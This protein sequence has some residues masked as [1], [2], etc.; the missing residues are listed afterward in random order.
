MAPSS[1]RKLSNKQRQALRAMQER[2]WGANVK[3]GMARAGKHSRE[4]RAWANAKTRCYNT[5]T[6]YYQNYGARGITMCDEWR[7]NFER[8][9]EDMGLCPVGYWLDRIDNEG[10]YEPR[11]CRWTTPTVQQRNSRKNRRYELNGLALT[12]PEWA[13]RTGLSKATIEKR[14]RIGWSMSDAVSLP[15]ERGHSYRKRK[16]VDLPFDE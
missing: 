3:H 2:A 14:L 13:E 15:V 1:I 8:F 5:K 10:N 16:Q 11:N 9:L 6:T 12:L 7:H 4:Y